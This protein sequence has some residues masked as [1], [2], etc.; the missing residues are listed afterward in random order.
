ML[1]LLGSTFLHAQNFFE[2][3]G[4][5]T[6][7]TNVMPNGATTNFAILTRARWHPMDPSYIQPINNCP[8]IYGPNDGEFLI[9]SAANNQYYGQT[10]CLGN[11]NFT[12]A[13]WHQNFKDHTGNTD[14]RYMLINGD[15]MYNNEIYRKTVSGLTVGESYNFSIWVANILNPNAVPG[16][17]STESDIPVNVTFQILNGETKIADLSTGN[18]QSQSSLENI[19]KEYGFSFIAPNT[20]ITIVI[21]NN[22]PGGC[23]N[24]FAIDDISIQRLNEIGVFTGENSFCDSSDIRFSDIEFNFTKNEKEFKMVSNAQGKFRYSLEK[25]KYTVYPTIKN[26]PYFTVVPAEITFELTDE[27][28]IFNQNF[29]ISPKGI[30]KD[31]EV[32]FTPIDAARPGFDASYKMVFKNKGNQTISGQVALNFN[33][34]LLDYVSSVP[35]FDQ[36]ETSQLT[37]NFK[38]LKPFETRTIN[39]GFNVNSPMEIPAVNNGDVLKYV[40]QI[41]TSVTDVTP[42]DNVFELEQRVVGSYDPNDKTC[43][44]GDVILPDMVGDYVH[45]K[46]RF[47]NTGDYYAEN[48]VIEDFIDT[49]KFDVSSIVVLNA[50]HEQKTRI[51]NNKVV[52]YFQNIK[53]PANPSP[54]RHGYVLFKIKTLP[55]LQL[56]DTF[57]NQAN[58]YFDYN[59]PIQTNTATTTIKEVKGLS[60]AEFDFSEQ[61]KLYP[62]P[63]KEVLNISTKSNITLH[64]MEIYNTMGQLVMAVAN[65][66]EVKSIPVSQLS[67]GTYI[68]KI[69]TDK[70]VLNS[71]FVKE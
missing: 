48:V 17:Y 38:D 41:V 28:N 18:I 69:N 15:G 13:G 12:Y 6:V 67:K 9:L 2:D 43:L 59:W 42:E 32:V 56:N 5:G 68:L 70:G 27:Q 61:I 22:A 34:G 60:N 64:S 3:F 57:S 35:T 46:I 26:S 54:D 11:N 30:R 1:V 65:A 50:S 44:E 16:C 52:F 10:N 20:S 14:G 33:D 66:K 47:E 40:A 21:R 29:C 37:W 39:V 31:L 58:I 25:G 55:T 49:T 53:L 4:S 8:I 19:W 23:G 62:I 36:S 71:V 45:Y 51:E 7:A 24:D 63:A